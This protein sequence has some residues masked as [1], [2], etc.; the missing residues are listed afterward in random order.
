[1]GI[2]QRCCFSTVR[3]LQCSHIRSK[4]AHP[5]L[6]FDLDN[7]LSMCQKCHIYWWHKEPYEAIEWLEKEFP[8]QAK[9]LREKVLN[10]ISLPKPDLEGLLEKYEKMLAE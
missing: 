5:R 2:C 7:A 10:E 4:K 1:M 9:R 8:D 6:E 3:Y